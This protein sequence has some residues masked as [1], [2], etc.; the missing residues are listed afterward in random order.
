MSKK[1]QIPADTLHQQ[2]E[3]SNPKNSSWVSANAGSGKTHVLTQRV[4]RLMLDGNPPDKIL[5]LTFTKAAAANMKNR[6]FETLGSWTMMENAELDAA[7]ADSTGMRVTSNLRRKARQLFASALDTPGGLKIQTIHGFCES[8]LHQFP[9]EAN[10][11]GH[12]EALQEI[13]QANLLKQAKSQ[14]LSGSHDPDGFFVSHLEALISE[15]NDSAIEAGLTEIIAKRNA[16]LE[17]EIENAGIENGLAK[18]YT[19]AGIEATDTE[20]TLKRSCLLT[21]PIAEA[22][23][24]E[25]AEL[26]AQSKGKNDLKLSENLFV[27]LT[28]SEIDT[29]FNAL[30]AAC[31]TTKGEARSSHNFPTK[32][33]K[34][35]I[36]D[37]YQY[38]AKCGNWLLNTLDKIRSLRALKNSYHLFTIGLAV[39]N[40][41][42]A[43]KRARGVID[44]DDQITKTAAL[45]TRKDIQDWIRYRL[46]RG[47]DHVLVDEA[48][49]TSPVQW[50]IINAIT[51]DFHVG[52]TASNVNRTTFVVGDEKQSIFSFQGAKPEEFD[53]QER[54]LRKQIE[55]ANKSFHPGKLGLSF[56]STKDVLHAV[57]KVFELEENGRG[58]TQSGEAPVHDAVRAN[59]PGEV[60]IWPIL[61]KAKTEETEDWLAP[62]DTETNSDPAIQLAEQISDKIG[63]WVGKPLPGMDRPLKFGDILVL[64]RKRDRFISALTRTMKD[65][66]LEIAGADRL[67]LTEHI[68]VEDLIALGRVALMPSDDLSLASVLKGLLF[69]LT[70][71][72]LFDFSYQRGSK[73]LYENIRVI[74]KDRAHH[75]HASACII[76]EKLDHIIRFSQNHDVFSFYALILGKMG[77]RKAILA[78]LGLEAEDV[79]DAFL[80]E[81]LTFA[82]ERN[83]GLEAFI[84]ELT[85][86]KPEIKREVELDRDQ[87]RIL[88]VHASKGL[89]A[90]LVFLVD[91]CGPAWNSSLRPKILSPENQSFLW[92]PDKTSQS[93]LA[94]D[95]LV[96]LERAAEAEYRRLLYV[97]MTRAA[98]RLIICGYKG[99]REIK[100]THW[101]QMVE[102]ALAPTATEL[103]NAHGEVTGLRWVSENKP[104]VEQSPQKSIQEE[105]SLSIPDWLFEPVKSDPPLPRPLTPSG[106]HALIE[107]VVI[108]AE[109]ITHAPD[110]DRRMA[111]E[112]GNAIHKLLELLP[113]M[114]P[115]EHKALAQKYLAHVGNHWRED[116][117]DEITNHVLS[118]LQQDLFAGQMGENSM[119]E[120]SLSGIIETNKGQLLISGQIDRLII[121]DYKITVLDYKSN[122]LVPDSASETPP[123]YLT[124]LALYREMVRQ[125]Y[126]GKPIECSLLWTQSPEIMTIPD[127]MLDNALHSIKNR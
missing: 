40:R 12:F 96:E 35:Q 65:K 86:A 52:D 69:N 58:L 89:E 116:Q 127:E 95:A 74:S 79:L 28:S 115:E 21:L 45:L 49:D 77:L 67:L 44:F 119:A 102:D 57:D 43:L 50:D 76:L 118:L 38:L 99:T 91:P 73:S 56:R 1:L 109:R 3:A 98:D 124:Q 22:T 33:V 112:R 80:D 123:E 110:Y 16:F 64:V 66:G 75:K 63:A 104:P 106:A 47:I 19:Q 117:R 85:A 31:L 61:E 24:K 2:F 30:S 41:Y 60:Q 88:T 59:D 7:I 4:I 48:Q 81:A 111:L 100:H 6:V 114:E 120:V 27:F 46:D 36:P 126:A 94:D 55:S 121:S 113:D 5:C 11:P 25:I 103:Q 17:W 9:L 71:E 54:A 23:L 108:P 62:I 20:E 15:N 39:V 107:D 92:V 90:R 51:A 37:A 125:I 8:L 42:E 101:H 87:V 84:T 53:G 78:R 82:R 105:P 93:T 10:V 32:F 18:I 13:E 122:Q 14:I 97:G 34:D 70:E 72:A 68:A 83:G 26:A 29:R